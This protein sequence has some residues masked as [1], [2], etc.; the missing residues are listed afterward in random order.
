MVYVLL[1]RL[2][3]DYHE[4]K[5]IIYRIEINYSI[6]KLIAV[7]FQKNKNHNT[8]IIILNQYLYNINAY[9]LICKNLVQ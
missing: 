1:F 2:S 6:I 9:P 3:L 5:I 7:K 4:I 8:N